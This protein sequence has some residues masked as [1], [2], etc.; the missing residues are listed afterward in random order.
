[1][2]RYEKSKKTFVYSV[3]FDPALVFSMFLYINTFDIFIRLFTSE[4]KMDALEVLLDLVVYCSGFKHFLHLR[5]E[6][7]MKSYEWHKLT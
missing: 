7:T 5:R 4:M 2:R 3:G 6:N 1:M